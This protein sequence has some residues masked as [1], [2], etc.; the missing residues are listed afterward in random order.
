MCIEMSLPFSSTF[1]C[2]G[3]V[4]TNLQ[5]QNGNPIAGRTSISSCTSHLVCLFFLMFMGLSL[6][7]KQ[8]LIDLLQIHFHQL[9]PLK[10]VKGVKRNM[11]KPMFCH[12]VLSSF[13]PNET[14]VWSRPCHIFAL[15]QGYMIFWLLGTLAHWEVE[16]SLPFPRHEKGLE[17]TWSILKKIGPKHAKNAWMDIYTVYINISYMKR[18][19]VGDTV[20]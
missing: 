16:V 5:N 13:P 1:M 8:Y 18:G 3:R 7:E 14:Q 15:R 19:L 6:L 10:L 17:H 4:M 12:R 11:K 20:C 9:D 2:W